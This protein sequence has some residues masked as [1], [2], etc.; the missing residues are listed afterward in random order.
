MTIHQ[1]GP[2]IE[3][4]YV[5]DVACPWCY[6]GL[7]RLKRAMGLRPAVPVRLRW[8][9]FMLNP[10]LPAAGIGRAEY[11]MAKFGPN[12]NRIYQRIEAVGRE[13]GIAFAFDRIR[14]QPNTTDAHRLIL[15]AQ[16]RGGALA[17]IDRLFQAFYLEGEDLGAHATLVALAK[18]AG[19]DPVEVTTFLGGDE[20]V[21]EVSRSQQ[22]AS[23]QGIRGVPVFI[24]GHAHALSGA[25]PAEVLVQLFDLAR[26]P[27]E[28]I[29]NG[30]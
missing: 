8:R 21:G 29:P 13:E 3:I 22:T 23:W 9:P 26:T 27:A 5:A 20:L 12:A 11:L 18:D 10:D 25:Q 1:T 19:L 28:Q 24:L 17:M 14:R 30:G 7:E 4:D 16:Q 2:A 6:V 15:L